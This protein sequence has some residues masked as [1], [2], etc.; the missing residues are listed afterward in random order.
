MPANMHI[1]VLRIEGNGRNLDEG[2]NPYAQNG[3]DAL[4]PPPFL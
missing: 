1:K 2:E 4:H 3:Q